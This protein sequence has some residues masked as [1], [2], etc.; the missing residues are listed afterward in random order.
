MD[1]VV[2]AIPFIVIDYIVC[3]LGGT[4]DL[5]EETML[6]SCRDLEEWLLVNFFL[7]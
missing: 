3:L 2:T 7:L 5:L 1:P 6:L 4:K